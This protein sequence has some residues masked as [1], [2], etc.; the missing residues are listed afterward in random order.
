MSKYNSHAYLILGATYNLR[1]DYAF[2]MIKEI[3]NVSSLDQ[4]INNPDIIILESEKSIKVEEIRV[5]IRNAIKAPIGNVKIIFIKESS[6]M[7][8]QAQN[9]LL[10]TLEEP[11]N[12]TIFILT[13]IEY[14]LLAT[15]RSRCN[16]IRLDSHSNY[17][18]SN[19]YET[20]KELLDLY[21][22]NNK[23][24]F[25]KK[26]NDCKQ[27]LNDIIDDFIIFFRDFA[28]SQYQTKPINVDKTIQFKSA[29]DIDDPFKILESLFECKYKL[30][31]NGSI[32]MTKDILT[33]QLFKNR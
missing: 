2:N 15:V 25:V 1:E 23:L 6:L 22:I 19:S 17:A 21:L 28:I 33:S 29:D 16:I 12:N 31:N 7:T 20:S 13:G 10:K 14:L 9:L 18:A 8:V 30:F 3:L 4:I 11:P 27:N 24:A 26:I 5:L 32:Q